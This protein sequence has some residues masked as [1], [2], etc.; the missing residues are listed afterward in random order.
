MTV[1]SKFT[2]IRCCSEDVRYYICPMTYGDVA[3]QVSSVDEPAA[4][5]LALPSSPEPASPEPLPSGCIDI[6]RRHPEALV[7][8]VQGGNPLFTPV[9]LDDPTGFFDG[10]DS[11]LGVLIFDGTQR[12]LL[13]DGKQRLRAIKDAL[14]QN[15]GLA[16]DD[17]CVM[18]V[19]SRTTLSIPLSRLS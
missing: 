15:Q 9:Y 1:T 18:I 16:K 12:Y 19:S 10:L 4:A 7:V 13:I 11:Q 2:A 8:A 14:Q 17:I 5:A 6:M 3:T